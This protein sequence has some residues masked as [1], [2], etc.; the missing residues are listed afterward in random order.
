M[1]VPPSST[2]A[3]V[4]L[5]SSSLSEVKFGD[6]DAQSLSRLAEEVDVANAALVSA[7][8]TL[9]AAKKALLEREEALLLHAQRALAYARVYAEND[10]ALSAKLGEIVLPRG[11][12]RSRP[13]AGGTTDANATTGTNDSSLGSSETLPTDRPRGRAKKAGSREVKSDLI[14]DVAAPA[15]E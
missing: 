3:L 1:S 12:R 9:E 5:F 2:K 10:E 7:Q 6:V 4:G 11:P 8:A 14:E 13:A 15:A